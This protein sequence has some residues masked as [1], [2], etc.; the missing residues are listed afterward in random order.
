MGYVI[1][2]FEFGN[3]FLYSILVGHIAL[4]FVPEDRKPK[5]KIAKPFLLLSTLGIIIFTLGPILQTI[6]YFKDGVG[7]GLAIRTVFIDFQVGKAWIFIGFLATFLWM[8]LQLNASKYLQ[9]LLILLMILGVGYSSHVASLS[10]WTGLISHSLHFLLVTLWTGILIHVA[11]LSK[12]NTDW[13]KFLRWFTPL[14][15]VSLII[16]F[17]SGFILMVFMVEPKDYVKA[18]VLPYGQ[19]LL[20]KHISIL[21]VL[22]FAII[23]GILVRKTILIHSFNPL[24]WIRGESIFLFIIFYITAVMGTL[25]PPHEIEFTLK[26]EGPSRWVEWLL[27]K[28]I[29]TTLNTH[30]L[31][32]FQSVLLIV[33]SIHFLIMIL[34]S[35][36]K[37][38][39]LLGVFMGL[40]FIVVLYIGMM[41]SLYI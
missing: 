26:S 31:T 39:P 40:C 29:T 32:N 6:Y 23:N 3:Y 33:I 28:N 25:S 18:W 9:A 22:V 1:P 27:G 19:M 17:I 34:I 11:W 24:P 8:A 35:F 30:F 20:L 10:F 15:L 12:E 38:K 41:F 5:S 36:K 13:G 4:Q 7:L 14:A 2:F 16:I 21:P 37:V